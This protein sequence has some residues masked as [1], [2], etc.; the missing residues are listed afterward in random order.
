MTLIK[1][2]LEFTKKNLIWIILII[3]SL[4]IKI[5]LLHVR[6]GDY[7]GFLHPWIAFIKSHGYF[8]S[9]K[10]GFYDYTPS[11]IYMLI[12]IAKIG[13]NPLYSV[14]IVSILFE[15][16]AAYFVGKIAFQKYKDTQTIW[17]SLAIIPLLPSILLNSSYLS[18]CDSIY[19]AF[20]L[21]S[22]YFIFQKK[23]FLSVLFLAVAFAFKMQTALILPFY[24]VLMLRGNIRWYYF[25]LI[26]IVFILSITPTWIFGR[27]FSDLLEV[28]LAQTDRFRFLTLNFPNIYIWISNDYYN[29]VKMLGIIFTFFLTLIAGFELS[30]KQFVFSFESWIT[31][32]FL[33]SII[34]PYF[35]P[36]MHERYMY[37]GDI[38]GVLYYLV[39]R[40]NIHLPVG[41][42]LVSFYSYIRCSRFND[43][44]P[45]SP[46]FFIYTFVIIFTYIDFIKSI[47]VEPND[48][49]KQE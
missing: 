14:K 45:M 43:I 27:S 38:L 28:Y 4:S 6:T 32:A 10:Y 26:P 21:G 11:Y 17:I 40:K 20:V 30:R 3:I 9:L 42:L 16:L 5:I 18:Q 33:S 46:A 35:L 13:F 29:L 34:V 8:S 2:N 24:F 15:Y 49:Y 47:K 19:A 36:G 1:K 31:L 23:Q 12:A 41:I 44:L 48:I 39:L 7:V 37:L 25:L 22:I